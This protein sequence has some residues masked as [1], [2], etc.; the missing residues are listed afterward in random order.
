MKSGYRV[1][2]Y[3]AFVS[4]VPLLLTATKL[5]GRV[6][7]RRSDS[8]SAIQIPDLTVPLMAKGAL[9]T[10]ARVLGDGG[11]VPAALPG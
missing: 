3:A 10:T 1:F 6:V 4:S 2:G 8:P 5:Y 7:W 9:R 11:M